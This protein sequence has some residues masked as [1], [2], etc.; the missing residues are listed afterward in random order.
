MNH[1]SSSELL[2]QTVSKFG[3]SKQQQQVYSPYSLSEDAREL[4]RTLATDL[5]P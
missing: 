1:D 5:I 3:K 2:T 4:L